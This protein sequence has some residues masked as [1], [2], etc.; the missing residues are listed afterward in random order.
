[1]RIIDDF[2]TLSQVETAK[3][4]DIVCWYLCLRPTMTHEEM[5][6][7]KAIARRYDDLHDQARQEMVARAR[8]EYA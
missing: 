1:M 2:P 7:L 3:P 4:Y 8:R 5:P 6:I